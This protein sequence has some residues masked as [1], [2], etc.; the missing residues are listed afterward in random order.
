M[1]LRTREEGGDKH[2]VSCLQPKDMGSNRPAS[3][4]STSGNLGETVI[5]LD[6][7]NFWIALIHP[8]RI[9][10]AFCRRKL[11]GWICS[12]MDSKGTRY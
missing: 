7:A 10:L 4:T 8:A 9:N 12:L 1:S 5:K 11:G 3:V 2:D 6:L